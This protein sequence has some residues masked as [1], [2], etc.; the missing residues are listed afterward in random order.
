MSR[1][2]VDKARAAI[3]GVV[4]SVL[5]EDLKRAA[6]ELAPYLADR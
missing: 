5:P 6:V 1:D 2:W 4:E 3:P